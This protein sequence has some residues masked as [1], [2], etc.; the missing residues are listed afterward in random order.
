MM[1]DLSGILQSFDLSNNGMTPKEDENIRQI[2][3]Q[4]HV[5]EEP[6][7]DRGSRL[8]LKTQLMR[9]CFGL[10]VKQSSQEK[11]G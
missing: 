4:I 5:P 10:F 3:D 7:F 2:I 9:T 8:F 11:Q 1:N 6:G